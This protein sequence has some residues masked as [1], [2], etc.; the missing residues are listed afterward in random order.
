MK[1]IVKGLVVAGLLVS[2][3]GVTGVEAASGSVLKTVKPA[4]DR[5]VYSYNLK[6]KETYRNIPLVGGK[7]YVTKPYTYRDALILLKSKSTTYKLHV[8]AFKNG[9]TFYVADVKD[10]NNVLR[11]LK[12][13]PNKYNT[14]AFTTDK[15]LVGGHG[16]I[17]V[18]G[19]LVTLKLKK[20][21]KLDVF[22]FQHTLYR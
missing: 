11:G 8:P 18:K 6:G 21:T 2:G 17:T 22:R 4:S 7:A 1:K 3:V 16:R 10:A 5:N 15:K 9:G 13:T 19:N 14:V 20:N 12:R